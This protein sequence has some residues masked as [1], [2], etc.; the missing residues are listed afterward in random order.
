MNGWQ[1]WVARVGEPDARAHAGAPGGPVS[2][3]PTA[4]RRFEHA[5]RIA[6]AG[7]IAPR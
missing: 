1:R 3:E 5:R 6:T 4:G 7:R 2:R